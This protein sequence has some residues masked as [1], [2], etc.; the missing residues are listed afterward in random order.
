MLTDGNISDLIET[1][2]VLVKLS[3]L[4]CSVIIV[5]LGTKNFS[6]MVELDGD[7]YAVSNQQGDI[8]ERDIVQ[9]FSFND[10]LKWNNLEE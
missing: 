7:D 8:V 10:A 1:R 5:G 2:D 4:P 6:K 9:F 3:A